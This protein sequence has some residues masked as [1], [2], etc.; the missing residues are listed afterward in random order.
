MIAEDENSLQEQYLENHNQ[1][2]E[3]ADE[4]TD[5]LLHNTL[6]KETVDLAQLIIR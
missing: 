6:D 3:V 1:E 2:N 5:Y 4:R